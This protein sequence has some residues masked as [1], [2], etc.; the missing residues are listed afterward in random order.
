MKISK[1][2]G[3]RI[4]VEWI[5]AYDDSGWKTYKDMLEIGDTVLCYTVGWYVGKTKDFLIVCHTKG[6]N[7]KEDMLGKL[8][9]PLKGIK[10]VK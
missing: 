2:Y 6:K 9:I 4:Y 5:D 3:D 8:V 7:T 10:K 1:K